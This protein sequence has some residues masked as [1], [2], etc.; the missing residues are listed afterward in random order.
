M[1]KTRKIIDQDRRWLLSTAMMGLAAVS[2]AS[3][4]PSLL[5]AAA[6]S[7]AIRPFRVHIPD[8]QLADLRRRILVT[9]WPDRETVSDQS[10]GSPLEKLQRLVRYWGTGYNWR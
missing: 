4:S 3:L 8:E 5:T 7:D 10:Q 1:T 9:R 2:A 6:G